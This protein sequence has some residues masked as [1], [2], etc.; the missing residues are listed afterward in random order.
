VHN[1]LL[2]GGA[3]DVD[4]QARMRLR[5]A[6]A[7]VHTT[8]LTLC[9]TLFDL[10]ARPAYSDP[11]RE[12][13]AAAAAAANHAETRGATTAPPEPS[14][15]TGAA[16]AITTREGL[17]RLSKLDSFLKESQRDNS[18]M[19]ISFLRRAGRDVALHDG[20]TIPRGALVGV[21]NGVMAHDMAR[22]GGREGK[23]VDDNFDGFRFHRLR[24]EA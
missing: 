14:P 19:T 9:H 2:V 22:W 16:S 23:G 5:S 12:E 6:F 20:V 24:R 8:N 3:G 15:M 10:A 4:S 21:A 13:L 11:L 7:A 18:F 17:V 1:S